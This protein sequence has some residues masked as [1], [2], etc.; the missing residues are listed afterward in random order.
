MSLTWKS[1][2][3]T[4]SK[5]LLEKRLKNSIP[6]SPSQFRAVTKVVKSILTHLPLKYQHSRLKGPRQSLLL[7]LTI[8]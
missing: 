3:F 1:H 4:I 5:I 6:M 7:I 2:C 8:I